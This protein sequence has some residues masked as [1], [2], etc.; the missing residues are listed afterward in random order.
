MGTSIAYPTL[1][2]L[3]VRTVNIFLVVGSNLLPLQFLGGSHKA[4][5]LES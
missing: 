4:L 3:A 2:V 1:S 5:D